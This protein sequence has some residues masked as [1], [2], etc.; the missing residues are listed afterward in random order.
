MSEE[1]KYDHYKAV[2]DPASNVNFKK[3]LIRS[4]RKKYKTTRSSKMFDKID[5]KERERA[6]SHDDEME[7]DEDKR[8]YKR[9]Q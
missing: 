8:A 3:K 2:P 7:T 4:Q 6:D 5:R 9:K 1:Y